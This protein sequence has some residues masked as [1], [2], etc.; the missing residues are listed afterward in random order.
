MSTEDLHPDRIIADAKREAAEAEQLVSALEEKVRSGDDSVTFEE[1]ERA[2]GLL[3]FVRLRQ[4]AAKR[5]AEAAREAARIDACEALNADIT[6]QVKGDGAK[7]SKQLK[8]AV[9]A[10]R[11]LYEAAEAR[12][13]NVRDF[14]RRAE[15]LGIPEQKH[16]GGAAPTHGGVRLAA[17]G[18]P[19]S[20]AGV[21]VG[22]RRV[23]AIDINV[24]VNRALNML[25]RENKYKH[26]EFVDA[27]ED[28]FGD[29]AAIDAEAPENSAKYFYR[30]PNGAVTA[31]DEPFPDDVIKR[32]NL[33]VITEAE[34]YAE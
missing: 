9:D 17:N 6:A 21:I 13:E 10:L 26:L 25:A 20:A 30:G 15:S 19:G 24:F 29:L 32:N 18:Y 34:A 11:E 1:V 22:R 33:R 4:E 16:S 5:K 28:L 27:G 12:N 31:K 14:R 23:D 2:R 7:F 8:T 3:G